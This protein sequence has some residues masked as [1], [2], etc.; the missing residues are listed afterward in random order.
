MATMT[1]A[2]AKSILT[3]GIIDS[4]IRQGL[5]AQKSYDLLILE[6]A[7]IRDI[8]KAYDTARNEI[9][10][11]LKARYDSLVKNIESMT[12][13]QIEMAQI[14]L[15]RDAKLYENLETRIAQLGGKVDKINAAA[16]L[17]ASGISNE[18]VKNEL[19][20]LSFF[21]NLDP[22]NFARI[23]TIQAELTVNHVNQGTV[24]ISKAQQAEIL[25]Q[26]QQ[27]IRMGILKG[28][29]IEKI[30]ER[31]VSKTAL[32]LEGVSRFKTLEDR[33]RLN[34]R[35]GI[36]ESANAASNVQYNAFNQRCADSGIN[37]RIKKQVI[38]QVDDRT[39]VCCLGAS[40]Q[41]QDI[42]VP[43]DTEQGSFDYPPF[44]CNCRSTTCAWNELFE[45]FGKS[46][47]DMRD[48]ANKEIQKRAAVKQ[49]KTA[50]RKQSAKTIATQKAQ[51]K[52]L[53]KAVSQTAKTVPNS[54]EPVT[55][56]IS[57]QLKAYSSNDAQKILELP[58]NSARQEALLKAQKAKVIPGQGDLFTT[59]YEIKPQPKLMPKPPPEPPAPPGKM[60]T[61]KWT[62]LYADD[63]AKLEKMK[64]AGSAT[65]KEMHDAIVAAEDRVIAQ[66]KMFKLD[67]RKIG[68]KRTGF[69]Q[70]SQDADAIAKR[71]IIKDRIKM[72][73]FNQAKQDMFLDYIKKDMSEV[74]EWAKD[75]RISIK[76]LFPPKT[77]LA[78][79][80]QSLNDPKTFIWGKGTK[81]K[82]DMD[83]YNDFVEWINTHVSESV[84]EKAGEVRLF[85]VMEKT[86]D[87]RAYYS[88][89]SR[90]IAVDTSDKMSVM[91]HE[92]GHHIQHGND[93][94]DQVL[95]YYFKGR[96]KGSTLKR[97]YPT[98]KDNTEMAYKGVFMDDYMGKVYESGT[99]HP[100]DAVELFSMSL[101]NIFE[102]AQRFAWREPEL[103]QMTIGIM[104]GLL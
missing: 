54:I 20:A 14:K 17:E 78:K 60:G 13:K 67:I 86:K 47:K 98:L 94:I 43:F 23:N 89:I 46:T 59:T 72:E 51:T 92:F 69:I 57:E 39:T 1:Y 24:F 100:R 73:F 84:L 95:S 12:P 75:H 16:I 88:Y 19:Q 31:I 102:D 87:S 80:L 22:Q 50:A 61:G 64:V 4:P 18:Y 28:E 101:Q 104:A 76:E 83:T 90:K 79:D 93:Q 103:F 85:E 27:Q 15:L 62:R 96:T 21:T 5:S 6:K 48:E 41:I 53:T 32:T 10:K 37:T 97:L 71:E 30:T 8:S 33:A 55:A 66:A 25:P 70:I 11:E 68:E 77:T 42:G 99:K 29:G 45:Q 65:Q 56:K 49:T 2:K 74:M 34:A 52:A 3:K 58:T 91:I 44:H 36:I 35:W 82:F 81:A 26:L 38:A 7:T 40:G 9:A 63:A